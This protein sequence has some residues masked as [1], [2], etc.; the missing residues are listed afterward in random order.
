MMKLLIVAGAAL[1]A[2]SGCGGTAT[3]PAATHPAATHTTKPAAT[4]SATSGPTAACLQLQHWQL[5]HTG[6][7]I[8]QAFAAQ[9]IRETAGAPLGLDVASWLQD[10]RAPIPTVTASNNVQRLQQGAEQQLVLAHAD[11]VRAD[12]DNLGVHDTIGVGTG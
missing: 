11:S 7:R 8:S 12:C 1:A 3:H 6:Q 2:L 9:L 10:I 5:H 4:A